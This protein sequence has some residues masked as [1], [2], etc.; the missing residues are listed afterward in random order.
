MDVEVLISCH[1]I[2]SHESL[3]YESVL[4]CFH[5]IQMM[6]LKIIFGIFTRC[7]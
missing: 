3:I 2:L 7:Q 4:V 5:F 1:F 6:Q